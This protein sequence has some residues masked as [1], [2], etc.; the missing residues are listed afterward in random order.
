MVGGGMIGWTAFGAARSGLAIAQETSA[1][2]QDTPAAGNADEPSDDPAD[3]P[4]GPSPIPD[5][6]PETEIDP[7]AAPEDRTPLGPNLFPFYTHELRRSDQAEIRQVLG[8][9]RTAR[10]PDG[11]G[12]TLLLPFYYRQHELTPQDDRF[13]LFPLYYSRESEDTSFRYLVP[14]YFQHRAP[15]FELHTV[16][17]FWLRLETEQGKLTQHHVLYP[18]G[19]FSRDLRLE[20]RPVS[21]GRLGLWKLL[22]LFEYRSTPRTSDSTALNL[23]NWSE[24]TRGGIA[25]YRSSWVREE[26]GEH[27]RRHLFPFYWHGAGAD[28]SYRWVIPLFGYSVDGARQDYTLIPLLS[29][30]GRG[31]GEARR[32]DLLFPLFH[33][34]RSNEELS[35][36]SYPFF[37]YYH[38]EEENRQGL[39]F[40]LYRRYRSNVDDWTTH[41]VLYPLSYFHSAEGG[42]R[43]KNWLLT[44]YEGWD[45]DERTRLILPFYVGLEDRSEGELEGFFT[46]AFPT[47]FSWSKGTADD[48]FAMGIPLYWHRN[49]GSRGWA[50]F[51]PFY[52]HFYGQVSRELHVI[53]F[54]SHLSSPFRRLWVFGGPLYSHARYFDENEQQTGSAHH[55]LWPFIKIANHD[56]GYDYRFLPFFW[57]EQLEGTTGLMVSPFYYQQTSPE[58]TSRY[59]F[60]FYAKF[61]SPRETKEYHAAGTWMRHRVY[62]DDRSIT[63]QS[64]SYLWYLA[65][66]EHNYIDGSNHQRIL[67]LLYWRTETPSERRTLSLPF[68]YSH[69]ITEHDEAHSLDLFL[70]NLFLSKVVEGPPRRTT[71]ERIGPTG[72]AED[73]AAVGDETTGDD[74]AD[75]VAGEESSAPETEWIERSRDQGVLWPLTRWYRT[76]Q[77]ESGHWIL[78]FYANTKSPQ[79]NTLAL[80]PLYYQRDEELAYSPSYFRYFYL[81]NRETFA[82]GYRL[83]VGQLL[84]DLRSQR[85]GEEWRLRLLYPLF[86]IETGESSYRYQITPLI[87]GEHSLSGGERATE[88]RL[89][90]VFWVGSRERL[91]RE[92]EWHRESDHFFL[93]PF[94]GYARRETRADYHALYPIF[95]LGR[96]PESLSAEVWPFFFYRDQPA[97]QAT[98]FWPLHANES[99]ETAGDF[100]V[101]RYLFLSKLFLEDDGFEYRFDPFL[102]R[103]GS[104]PDRFGMGGLFELLAY[105]RTEESV[106]FRA[107]PFVF[108]Y[109]NPESAATAVIPLHYRRDFGDEAI[110]RWD[111]PR[112]FFL[113]NS[114]RG[115]GG[116]RHFSLLTKLLEYT[117]STERPDFYEFRLLHR[118][119]LHYRSETAS[120]VEWNPFFQYYRDDSTGEST[121]SILGYLYRSETDA[122]GQTRRTILNFIPF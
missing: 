2:E 38:S 65:T 90:P 101:S 11:T 17:P 86:E 58:G 57:V 55:L 105:D 25:L 40:W 95:H 5:V 31:P 12:S 93:F 113:T 109:S 118:L 119:V 100:W 62:R 50:V 80:F 91:D 67:P 76:D 32:F 103:Y 111:F 14:F 33:Y 89:F 68:Y 30:F 20:N 99:G 21:S 3:R 94:F 29:R 43:G 70:G 48:Y 18:F 114:A 98:R 106:S 47:Y 41:S 115:K 83:S 9:Y 92:G 7:G 108:G 52:Y 42:K 37:D 64:S 120:Q 102:F 87:S 44:Y 22:E 78:P 74:A 79:Q 121:F 15:T 73:A 104:G 8:L 59:L 66:F 82:D 49:R 16:P 27:G 26:W 112:F 75:L 24:E 36:A 4:V 6:E 1:T 60:P 110:D 39:L 61:E 72:A 53:P 46:W 10:R 35:V 107:I 34:A 117:Y 69:R 116:E 63:K 19:R 45:P 56:T 51:A 122:R 13:Y 54:V 88:H 77:G 81:F 96:S 97:L 71:A 85:D 28:S 23:L 84:F